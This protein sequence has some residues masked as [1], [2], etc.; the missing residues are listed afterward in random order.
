MTVYTSQG[1]GVCS[2]VLFSHNWP[3]SSRQW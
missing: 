2:R 3:G 1:T